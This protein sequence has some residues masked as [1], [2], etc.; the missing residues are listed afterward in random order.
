MILSIAILSL[1]GFIFGALY[2]MF[3]DKYSKHWSPRL[4]LCAI[5]VLSWWDISIAFSIIMLVFSFLWSCMCVIA[6]KDDL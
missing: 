6:Q 5:M 4:C 3:N 2:D 1:I